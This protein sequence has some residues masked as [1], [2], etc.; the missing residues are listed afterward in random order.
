M[1]SRFKQREVIS[2]LLF[3]LLLDDLELF[4]ADNVNSDITIDEIMFILLLFENDMVNL[5]SSPEDFQKSL[6][7]LN[8]HCHEWGLTVDVEKTKI[9]AFRKRGLLRE[10]VGWYLNNSYIEV[11]NEVVNDFNYL[12]TVVNY[13][14]T[15]ILNNE[16]ITGKGLNA[17][18]TLIANTSK[19]DFKVKILLDDTRFVFPDMF[20]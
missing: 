12:G 4:L 14:G 8:W 1:Y 9:V 20:E 6:D 5:G 15:F 18:H 19:Y 13:T 2:P 16:F 10:N 17:L 7:R 3:S 11:I